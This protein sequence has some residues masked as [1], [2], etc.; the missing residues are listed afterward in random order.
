M[1]HVRSHALYDGI[2]AIP[3]KSCDLKSRAINRMHSCGP[4]AEV[5]NMPTNPGNIS[6]VMSIP[7]WVSAM[8][9]S[10]CSVAVS[11]GGHGF[12]A[13]HVRRERR[14]VSQ[15]R[16]KLK[17]RGARAR[18]A[19]PEQGGHD[20][21][22]VDLG[23]PGVPLLDLEPAGQEPHD[24][25]DHDALTQLVERRFTGQRL[26]QDVESFLPGVLPEVIRT[27]TRNRGLDQ[28]LD[29]NLHSPRSPT[30]RQCWG[31]GQ[32]LRDRRGARVPVIRT[33]RMVRNGPD[34]S[35]SGSP[36]A[37]SRGGGRTP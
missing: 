10:V 13:S 15:A 2:R 37:E 4:V 19:E 35:G 23:M 9:G 6:L 33:F 21:L 32:T 17:R 7:T 1:S 18:E 34:L 26:D 28:L 5:G 12:P 11:G 8:R 22:V 25:V 31:V 27:R 14:A 29:P 20:L 3:S 16:R 36:P 24:L 30:S